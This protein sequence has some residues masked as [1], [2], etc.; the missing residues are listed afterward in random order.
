MTVVKL[1]SSPQCEQCGGD[2][3]PVFSVAG[4]LRAWLCSTCLWFDK[5]VGREF[6]I[7]QQNWEFSNGAA[8]TDNYT[9]HSYGLNTG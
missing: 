9:R 2:T 3:A 8:E 1:I 6:K 4:S 7:N 5:P